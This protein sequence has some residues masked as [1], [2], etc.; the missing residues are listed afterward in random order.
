MTPLLSICIPT[1]NRAE[2]LRGILENIVTDPSFDERVE[3]V[4]SDN[5]STDNTKAIGEEYAAGYDNIKYYRNEKNIVDRNFR[6]VLHHATGKY[7][8]IVNDTLRFQPGTIEL[9]LNRIMEFSDESE[10]LFF[11]NSWDEVSAGTEAVASDNISFVNYVSFYVGWIGGFGLWRSDIECIDVPE[12]YYDLKFPQIAWSFEVV[13]KHRYSRIYFGDLFTICSLN[14]KGS[15]N[16]FKVQL[17]NLLEIFSDYGIK[18]KAYRREKRRIYEHH[19][20]YMLRE[21]L[22]E[23]QETNFDLTGAWQILFRNYWNKPYFY[24][25]FVAPAFRRVK[26]RVCPKK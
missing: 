25:S 20:K 10:A 24:W 16:F 3:V 13:K 14:K 2:Y 5:A 18:G 19:L 26:M 7:L 6:V 8:K 17:C 9:M 11:Q 21:Y 4:I 22:I 23:K 15:Y 12:K 1:F